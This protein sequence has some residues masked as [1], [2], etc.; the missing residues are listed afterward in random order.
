MKLICADC[1]RECSGDE[2]LTQINPP[3][4][5]GIEQVL[6]CDPCMQSERWDD[7]KKRKWPNWPNLPREDPVE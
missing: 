2:F 5:Y 6:V 1:K 3:G 7:W 4:G